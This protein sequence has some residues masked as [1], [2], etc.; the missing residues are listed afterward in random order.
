[1]NHIVKLISIYILLVIL[2][3]ASIAEDKPKQVCS[4]ATF[5]IRSDFLAGRMNRCQFLADNTARI[6]IAPEDEPPINPSPWYSFQVV[7]HTAA[8][9]VI[10]MVY[11]HAKHRYWPKISQDGYTWHPL[12]K[13]AFSQ[14]NDHIVRI[15]LPPLSEPVH[16]SGQEILT[17]A[18]HQLWM[19]KM[20]EA[21]KLTKTALGTSYGGKD[22]FKLET[23]PRNSGKRYIVLVGR[24]HPPEITGALA[25][26]PFVE[27]IYADTPLARKFRQKFGV[28]TVPILNPDGVAKGHWRHSLGDK[29]LN[30]DWGPFTQP[31]IQLMRDELARFKNDDTLS[32]FLDFHSTRRNVLYTQAEAEKTNPEGF[33]KAW[34][35]RVQARV[36]DYE[37]E[38][39]ERPWTELPTS[40]NYVYATYGVPAI[41]YEVGDETDRAAL[42][43]AAKIFAEEMMGV[44]LETATP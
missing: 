15:S 43:A 38:R 12:A 24:Q 5:D 25:L 42:A 37:F 34:V 3:V 8:P 40:K 9:I 2:S 19:D 4:S 18:A 1:M 21:H 7:P 30:R 14:L 29:D 41:T 22:I 16:I 35:E 11:Q 13:E 28:I 26:M 6:E 33:T 20:V 17:N 27:A 39:A 36:K 10:E 32:L 44:L 31:E 23:A